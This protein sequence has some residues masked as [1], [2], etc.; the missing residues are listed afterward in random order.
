[1]VFQLCVEI[2]ADPLE[3]ASLSFEVLSQRLE[4]RIQLL[5]ALIDVATLFQEVAL[6]RRQPLFKESLGLLDD[7]D[8]LVEFV[9][10]PLQRGRRRPD[11]HL[12]SP[13]EGGEYVLGGSVRFCGRIV[14]GLWTPGPPRQ[15]RGL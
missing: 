11:R 1:L 7:S 13:L 14:S 8:L 3:V 4:T 12:A 6:E 9:A 5:Q 15:E 10:N 2:H